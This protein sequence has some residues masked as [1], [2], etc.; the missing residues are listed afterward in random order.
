LSRSSIAGGQGPELDHAVL[1][2]Q[3]PGVAAEAP[4]PIRPLE[5]QQLGTLDREEQ[6]RVHEDAG[7]Q[8]EAP[9]RVGDD[10]LDRDQPRRP[11][12]DGGMAMS[13]AIPGGHDDGAFEGAPGVGIDHDCAPRPGSGG[14]ARQARHRREEDECRGGEGEAGA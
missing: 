10:L 7:R 9:L 11:E 6:R 14:G 3:I 8:G 2:G 13:P 1:S 4:A 12:A 5:D